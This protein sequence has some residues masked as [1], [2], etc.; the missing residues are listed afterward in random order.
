MDW[1]CL[2]QQKYDHGLIKNIINKKENEREKKKLIFNNIIKH[3]NVKQ[4]DSPND[5]NTL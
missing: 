3:N 4:N 2:F 1:H 5:N